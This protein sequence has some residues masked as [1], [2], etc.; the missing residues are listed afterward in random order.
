MGLDKHGYYT[1]KDILKED[2]LYNIIIGERAPGKSYGVKREVIEY[3]WKHKAPTIA[4][5]RR[6]DEDIKNSAVTEYFADNNSNEGNSGDIRKIT[7]GEYDTLFSYQSDLYFG[8]R[9]PDS[10]QLMRGLC[11]GKAFALNAD[12]RYKSRQFPYMHDIIYEEFVTNKLYL[13]DECNRLQ[14]FVSTLFRKREGRVW[15]IANTISRV[16]PYFYEWQLSKIP[17]M[18]PGQIDTYIIDDTKLAVEFA[19]SAP[20]KSRM[21]FGKSAKSIQG[22]QWETD[23]YPVLPD[24]YDTYDVIY[25]MH[26]KTSFFEHIF[27]L[28][29]LVDDDGDQVLFIQPVLK[30]V[31]PDLPTLSDEFNISRNVHRYLR[32]DHKAERTIA[33]LYSEQK[34]CF[35]SNLTGADFTAVI[36]NTPGIMTAH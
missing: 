36:R 33:R 35:S 3:A 15:M 4:L 22:A 19:P 11:C 23:N 14:Q 31:V 6:Y 8:N 16:C 20:K 7:G 25:E 17:Y 27:L 24:D 34:V 2:A 32:R 1:C 10:G 5:L 26:L 18:T 9:D 28:Q 13:R 30:K 21:F 29:L 12:E